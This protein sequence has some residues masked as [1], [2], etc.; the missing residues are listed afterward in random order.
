MAFDYLFLG[1][2]LS[3]LILL[4]YIVIHFFKAE[5]KRI[6]ELK[7]IAFE[8]GFQFSDKSEKEF[9]SNFKNFVLFRNHY[10]N[11]VKNI[12][13]G[14]RNGINFVLFDQKYMTG[15]GGKNSS[16]KQ[17]TVIYVKLNDFSI[18]S[19]ILKPE[20]IIHKI[21]NVVGFKDIDF[22]TNPEFS[23]KYFLKGN[24]TQ[25]VK[26]LFIP[27]ILHFFEIKQQKATIECDG[28]SIIMYQLDKRINSLEL[29]IYLDEALQ[30][31]RVFKK[32]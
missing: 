6:N 21:G 14:K 1:I 3:V 26:A 18:P 2:L 11:T 32:D 10:S 20:N 23:K 16:Q 4:I 31:I 15:S 25:A 9:L 22:D 24:D 13:K 29:Q 8:R 30:V 28:N 7:K 27:D 19:F 5:Q 17:Q 12:I